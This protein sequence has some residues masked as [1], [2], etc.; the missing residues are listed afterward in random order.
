MERSAFLLHYRGSDGDL[1]VLLLFGDAAECAA[2][3]KLDLCENT[4]CRHHLLLGPHSHAPKSRFGPAKKYP[5][6]NP[7]RAGLEFREL[8]AADGIIVLR[9]HLYHPGDEPPVVYYQL[10][11]VVFPLRIRGGA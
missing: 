5:G 6:D 2:Y 1:P 8:A 3:L 7:E 4:E 10:A 9:W 11:K